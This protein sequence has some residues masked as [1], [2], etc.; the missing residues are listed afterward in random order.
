MSPLTGRA[1]ERTLETNVLHFEDYAQKVLA[2]GNVGRARALL[3][4]AQG[5]E[6][7]VA[8]S[9][10]S[11]HWTTLRLAEIVKG[12]EVIKSASTSRAW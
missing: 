5:M 1:W 2:L 3:E 9:V 7:I 4:D 6:E 8:R 11:K 10:G 12:A